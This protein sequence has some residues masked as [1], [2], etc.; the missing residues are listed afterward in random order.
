MG[1]TRL[2]HATYSTHSEATSNFTISTTPNANDTSSAAASNPRSL[3]RS[4]TYYRLEWF[5]LMVSMIVV[6]IT[7][8]VVFEIFLSVLLVVSNTA[9]VVLWRQMLIKCGLII[10][11]TTFYACA[12]VVLTEFHAPLG[13]LLERYLRLDRR[14]Q[15]RCLRVAACTYLFGFFI[16]L[17]LIDVEVVMGPLAF[18]FF[19]FS[20]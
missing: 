2:R 10:A 1:T 8:M 17:T 18:L 19:S 5:W 20:K 15:R 11:S 13:N 4:G 3:F 14:F 7:E 9:I 6:L 16:L 12:F